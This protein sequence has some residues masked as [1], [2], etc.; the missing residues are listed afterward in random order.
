MSDPISLVKSN[1][2][3]PA[4]DFVALRRQGI[5]CIERLSSE[6]W[7]DYNVSDPGITILEAVCYA[8]TDLSYR[9]S[10]EIKDLLARQEGDEDAWKQIFYTAR[11]ILHNSA[12]TITDYRKLIIDTPGVRNAWITPSKDYEVPLWIDYKQAERR[13]EEGC[14]CD[15]ADDK[16]CIGKLSLYPW[17]EQGEGSNDKLVKNMQTELANAQKKGAKQ[18]ELI[19]KTTDPTAAQDAQAKL[20]V[21]KKNIERLQGKI[22]KVQNINTDI[23]SK[24]VE[25]E[26]LLNVTIEYEEDILEEARREDVRQQVIERLQGRRNLCEDFLSVNA[27]EYLD[28]GIGASIEL[29]EAADPDK[30]LSQIFFVIY[31]YFTPSVPFYTIDQLIV[32]G[33]SVDEIFEGPALRNGFIRTEDMEATDLFRDIRLSDI[34]S[35]V[36]DIPGIKAILFLQ[37]PFNGF[38]D[39]TNDSKAFFNKWVRFLTEERLV[40]RIQPSLSSIMFCKDAE[41]ITY[42]INPDTDRRPDRMLKQFSDLKALER[43]YRL[44]GTPLDFQVPEGQYKDLQ[45]YYPVTYS[46]PECYGVS[47]RAGLPEDAS[48]Q[49]K[50]QALQLKGY[51]LFFEQILSDYLVQ[52]D[53]LGALFTFDD[54]TKTTQY[55]RVLKELDG[56]KQLLADHAHANHGAADYGKHHAKTH[57][58]KVFADFTEVLENL[59]EIPEAFTTRRNRF[60]D[61]MLARFGE[62]MSEYE[63]LMKGLFPYK[64]GEKVLGDK[65]RMLKG[66]EYYQISTDR[67]QGYNY[68]QLQ[69]WETLNVSGT[70]RRVS[71][72]L[73]FSSAERRSLSPENIFIEPWQSPQGEKGV[74]DKNEG[75]KQYNIIRLT[76]PKDHT[77][78]LLTSVRA[79][80]G[81]CTEELLMDILEHAGE[82]RYFIFH[83]E[84]KPLSRK[85]AGI[86]GSFWYE[87]V[88][89]T[90]PAKAVSLASGEKY[91]NRQ[92]RDKAFRR[93]Q[94]VIREMDNNEGLHLVEHLLLR[95]KMDTVLDE[96]GAPVEVG[97]LNICLDDCDL[98]K[99]LNEGTAVP[100]YRK[101]LSRTP[102]EKC[103]DNLPWV[104]EYMR[105]EPL[106]TGGPDRSMLFAEAFAETADS[107]EPVPLKFR[108]YEALTKRVRDLQEF[109]SERA[110]YELVRNDEEDDL[111]KVK[112][113]FIIHGKGGEVLAQSPFLFNK[114]TKKQ[115]DENVP[116]DDDI[117][118][119]IAALV[120][121][122]GFELDLYCEANPCDHNEDPYSFR[123]TAVLPCWPKRF[124]NPTFRH[125][126]EKTI[127]TESPAHVHVNVIWVGVAEMRRFEEAYGTWLAETAQTEAPTYEAVNPLVNVLNTIKPCGCCNDDCDTPAQITRVPQVDE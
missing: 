122:F 115:R 13:T 125:F 54:S 27:A 16:I 21:I 70:E 25:L 108:R 17:D 15:D 8:I 59:T 22:E 9:T 80:D 94:E 55:G 40:A 95:P 91:N 85:T 41:F 11:Q 93:L 102:A 120:Q 20:D 119:E 36:A 88:D 71:R 113:S 107:K 101:R 3:L 82:R 97:L 33:M 62:D 124:R 35:E 49:R 100:P 14:S 65:I 114:Q 45:D 12:L 39:K 56:I 26:G 6:L 37:L 42:N 29:E 19:K 44:K 10:F 18:E 43:K 90:D 5:E 53:N 57:D 111:T 110:N 23:P 72:L 84:R 112:W 79:K 89:D 46:L 96:D 24:I 4:Q 66:S 75:D 117:E 52:L 64:A 2:L 81:C 7:T 121:Y 109:G 30:I 48:P 32:K 50:A 123:A 69:T 126:V 34:M 76:D 1:P 83:D 73:G 63:E 103:Y 77:Y 127:L 86:V 106:S 28:F 116:V 38:N 47:E 31:K 78:N 87:L 74:P 98:N 118:K 104:L 67:A 60:L 92:D 105:L 99:G 68:T 61:H 58:E 51:M